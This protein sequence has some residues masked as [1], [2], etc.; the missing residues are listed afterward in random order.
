MHLLRRHTISG[1]N[2]L[3][4]RKD[5]IDMSGKI[6]VVGFV[7]YNGIISFNKRQKFGPVESLVFVLAFRPHPGLCIRQSVYCF[8]QVD[9]ACVASMNRPTSKLVRTFISVEGGGREEKNF[10]TFSL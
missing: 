5:E 2:Y 4:I 8:G 9:F 10:F 1:L 7:T 3:K 6:K